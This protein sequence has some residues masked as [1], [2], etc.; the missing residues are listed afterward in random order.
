M[1]PFLFVAKLVVQDIPLTR[2][3][4]T[5]SSSIYSSLACFLPC[6]IDIP[7]AFDVLFMPFIHLILGLSI[8]LTPITFALLTLFTK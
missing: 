1:F 8:D 5:Q 4:Y 7:R 2:F 3:T 6:S